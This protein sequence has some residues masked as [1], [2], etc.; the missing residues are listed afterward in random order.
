[1]PRV[2]ESLNTMVILSDRNEHE[3]YARSISRWDKVYHWHVGIFTIAVSTVLIVEL[4]SPATLSIYWPML[5]WSVMMFGHFLIFRSIH[6]DTSWANERARRVVD[7]S[8]DVD[9]IKNIR[10]A[11][12]QRG[13]R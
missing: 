3:P 2:Y 10:K 1:M 12:D 13:R 4:I 8:M 11:R 9:H 5:I 7:Q 6:V